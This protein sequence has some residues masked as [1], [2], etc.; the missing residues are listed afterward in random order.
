[1]SNVR[2]HENWHATQPVHT[3]LGD[4]SRSRVDTEPWEHSNP[5]PSWRVY[6]PLPSW[7]H[8]SFGRHIQFFLPSGRAAPTRTVAHQ[9]RALLSISAELPTRGGRN[10]LLLCSSFLRCR[11]TNRG[12]SRLY[13]S[14]CRVRL[15]SVVRVAAKGLRSLP[16]CGLTL[17]SR[18]T[19]K[20]YRPRPPL[21][22]NVRRPPK[23]HHV[24]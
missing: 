23:L 9:H 18:G 16:P 6:R 2:P 21:M 17:P 3:A 20:G 8:H 24:L 22:S 1:M 11:H 4:S 5:P 14:F 7:P 19:S 13:S 12:P 15:L 10:C